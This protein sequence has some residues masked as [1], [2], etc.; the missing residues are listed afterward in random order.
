MPTSILVVA[1]AATSSH[2]SG[3]GRVM[4]GEKLSPSQIPSN[5]SRSMSRARRWMPSASSAAPSRSSSGMFSAR[6]M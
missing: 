5:P 1:A 3:S 2:M 4:P 6:R